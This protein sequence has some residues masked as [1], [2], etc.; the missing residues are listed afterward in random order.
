MPMPASPAAT[1]FRAAPMD[2]PFQ[3]FWPTPTSDWPQ[4]RADV[5]GAEAMELKHPSDPAATTLAE[6]PRGTMSSRT[7]RPLRG[8]RAGSKRLGTRLAAAASVADGRGGIQPCDNIRVR[9]GRSRLPPPKLVAVV[10]GVLRAQQQRPVQRAPCCGSTTVKRGSC[11]RA[12]MQRCKGTTASRAS[13]CNNQFNAKRS[14][15]L[16]AAARRRRNGS[17]PS[18]RSAR[19]P[20]ALDWMAATACPQTPGREGGSSLHPDRGQCRLLCGSTSPKD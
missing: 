8:Q 10:R 7:P 9:S 15:K 2:W 19:K 3:S 16:S 4:H 17:G 12:R 13:P 20:A 6:T 5:S 14:S 1:A 11:C 18:I